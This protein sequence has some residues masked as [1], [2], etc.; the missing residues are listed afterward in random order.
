MAPLDA[1]DGQFSL[2]AAQRVPPVSALEVL[3][4]PLLLMPIFE[5]QL[6]Q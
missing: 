2:L 5:R 3:F 6:A 1:P 4:T